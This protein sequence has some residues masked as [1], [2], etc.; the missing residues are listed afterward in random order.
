MSDTAGERS[1]LRSSRRGQRG[2]CIHKCCSP[3]ALPV[4][5]NFCHCSQRNT[6]T[7]SMNINR[8]I[9]RANTKICTLPVITLNALMPF[10][11]CT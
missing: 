8:V 1:A 4:K 10:L 7:Y 6:V 11:K 3:S 5:M 2:G 9:N